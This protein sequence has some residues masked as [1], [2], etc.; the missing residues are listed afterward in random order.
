MP[1]ELVKSWAIGIDL[2]TANT[3]VA[4][5]RNDRL[6][7][8]PDADGGHLMPSCVS[9]TDRGR[10]IGSPAKRQSALNPKNTVFSVKRLFGRRFQEPEVRQMILHHPYSVAEDNGYPIINADYMGEKRTF[11]IVEILSMILSRAKENAEAYLGSPVVAA[12]LGIPAHFFTHH[13]SLILDAATIAG[14]K[15]IHTMTSPYAAVTAYAHQTM[16]EKVERNILVFDLGAGSCHAAL[17]TTEEGIIDIKAVFS[18]PCLGGEDFVNRLVVEQL[19]HIKRSWKTDIASNARALRRLRTACEAAIHDLSSAALASITISSLFEGKDWDSTITRLRFEEICQDLFRGTIHPIERVLADGGMGKSQV[20]QVLLVGGCSRILRV[21]KLIYSFF[22]GKDLSKALNPDEADVY[23]LAL[24]AAILSGE[25]S[26]PRLNEILTLEVL[27]RSIGCEVEGGLMKK[28]VPRNTTIPT[29][30]SE[31]LTGTFNSKYE[32]Y[33]SPTTRFLKIFEGER[34]RTKDNVLLGQIDIETIRASASELRL[35]CTLE[36]EKFNYK[37]SCTV[38]CKGNGQSIK[39]DLDSVG[40]LSKREMNRMIADARRY[41]KVDD[42]EAERVKLRVDLDSHIAALIESVSDGATSKEREELLDSVKNIRE[43]ADLHEFAEAS[44][45]RRQSQRLQDIEK[46]MESRQQISRELLAHGLE[47]ALQKANSGTLTPS[48]AAMLSEITTIDDWFK[49]SPQTDPFEYQRRLHQLNKIMARLEM[50]VEAPKIH[51]SE[52]RDTEKPKTTG[53]NGRAQPTSEDQTLESLFSQTDGITPEP[54]SDAQF[55]RISTFLRNKG[56]ASWSTVP[57]LYTVLRLINQLDAMETFLTQGITDIWFPFA[58]NTLPSAL[59]P[60][61]KFSFLQAQSVALSKGFKLEKGGDRG[62]IPFSRD[63]VLPFQVIG[64][65]GRGAHGSVDKV[66]SIISHREYARKTFRK[67]GGLSREKVNTFITELKVLKRVSHRHCVELI[68]SYSDAK[69]FALIM[70][71]VGDYNLAEY[72]QKA[73]GNADMLS[74]MRSFLGCLTSALQ[75]LHGSRIRHRDIKPQN[76]VVK[77]DCPLIT[78]FGIAYSWENLKRGTTTADSSKTMIYAAPEV[79]RVEARNESADMWSLGCVFLEIAT[80]LKG[81]EVQNMRERFHERSDRYDF[82]ANREEI[83]LWMEQLRGVPTTTDDVVL[84]WA[85]SMLQP[86]SAERPMAAQ[87][88]DE[89]ADESTRRGV[90]FCGPCCLDDDGSTSNDED[91]SHLWC[92]SNTESR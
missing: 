18:D 49:S 30:K 65:L 27:P 92:D 14:L 8:I 17:A 76:I 91:D 81:E 67:T 75:Y 42:A 54:F 43:W 87:L 33:I 74:L 34:Q 83:G 45:Y 2:G 46:L 32:S 55:E 4:V 77:G 84:D 24:T 64:R 37:A 44:E 16:R 82:H 22:D 89:I 40:H 72:Y 66:M 29:K 69:H 56:D 52:N 20:D 86:V 31:I 61:I 80:V 38:A 39:L 3:R 10:L 62:H 73:K 59:N 48:R 53:G 15:I 6:E 23:G 5:F 21:Q 19:N 63:E 51:D 68:G 79:V 35:E 88:F 71:P 12:V 1:D 50:T 11:S 7:I 60:T 25:T 70:E 41:K 57:R 9:F 85:A 26:S 13:R 90:L 28:L 78:D 58:A 47:E 36:V